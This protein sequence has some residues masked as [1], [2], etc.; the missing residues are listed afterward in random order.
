MLQN[1][2][3][4]RDYTQQSE[5]PILQSDQGRTLSDSKPPY[6][7]YKVQFLSALPVRQAIIRMTQIDQKYDDLKSEQKQQLDQQAESFLAQDMS[8]KV[9]VYIT[10]ETNQPPVYLDKIHDLKST[11]TEMI[12]Y[13]VHL[14]GSKGE[15]VPLEQFVAPQ[16]AQRSFQLIFPRQYHGKEILGPEDKSLNLEF[17]IYMEF[18]TDKMKI[19]GK[20]EY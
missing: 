2:P 5:M 1:S 14:Y 10:Y 15:K 13:R 6:V 17:P 16:G 19:D 9:I 3:W 8:K 18:K 12:I 20:V 11:T 4:A 7:K